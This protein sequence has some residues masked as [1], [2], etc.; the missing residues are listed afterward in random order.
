MVLRVTL[1]FLAAASARLDTR[2]QQCL[3]EFKVGSDSA[4]ERPGRRAAG[5]GTHEVQRNT[6]AKLCHAV[7][8]ETRV[9]AYDTGVH[10]LDAPLDA[11]Q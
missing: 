6:T 10:A 7:F 2:E 1:A 8:G 11:P 3:C 5:V 4:A 9:S